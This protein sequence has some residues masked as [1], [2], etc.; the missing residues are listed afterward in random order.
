MNC[1]SLIESLPSLC[2]FVNAE[3][4]M[5]PTSAF[6]NGVH[7]FGTGSGLQSQGPGGCDP[8]LQVRGCRGHGVRSCGAH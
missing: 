8:A 1:M 2:F 6:P 7:E 5:V 3:V 4:N